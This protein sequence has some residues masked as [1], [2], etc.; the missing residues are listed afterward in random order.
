MPRT[1]SREQF[2]AGREA[3]AN[4]GGP[5]WAKAR[6]ASREWTAFP[7]S[8]EGA[9]ERD[10][11]HPSQR[12]IIWFALDEQPG[13][14]LAIIRRSRSW[15]EVINGII[16]NLNELRR[17]ADWQEETAELERRYAQQDYR[18]AMG[19]LGDLLRRVRDSA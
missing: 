1:Y 12:I 8:E 7:P 10:A 3:W 14:T 9:D 13:A 6:E 11:S 15:H 19:H 2:E 5:L 16:G 18:E 4:F 17:A